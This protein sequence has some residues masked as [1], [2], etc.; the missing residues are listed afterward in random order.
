MSEPALGPS[1]IIAQSLA[2]NACMPRGLSPDLSAV[3]LVWVVPNP[4]F[5][6]IAGWLVK[7]CYHE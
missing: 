2:Y 6:V 3:V 7:L 5:P 4:A 1:T